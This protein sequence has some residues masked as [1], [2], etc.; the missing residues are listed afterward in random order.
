MLH[1]RFIHNLKASFILKFLNTYVWTEK[2][3]FVSM[4]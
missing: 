1:I 2:V 3:K 4:D